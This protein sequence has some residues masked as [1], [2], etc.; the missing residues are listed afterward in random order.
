MEGEE[1]GTYMYAPPPEEM[2]RRDPSVY[3]EN[4]IGTYRRNQRKNMDEYKMIDKGYRKLVLPFGP[5]KIEVEYY[6]T[7]S[8]P[9]TVIRD[10]ITGARMPQ[11]RVGTKAEELY[12]KT[13]VSLDKADHEGNILFFNSPEQYERHMYTTVSQELKEEWH[14]R[15]AI[16][17]KLY[18]EKAAVRAGPVL[19]K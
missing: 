12:F 10:A 4:T 7:S 14:N 2:L 15:C 16:A 5:Q 1:L 11:H 8:T 18:T 3:S 13:R 6:H 19:I 17:D 9:G